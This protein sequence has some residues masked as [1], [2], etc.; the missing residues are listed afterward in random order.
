MKNSTPQTNPP[1]KSPEIIGPVTESDKEFPVLMVKDECQNPI[2]AILGFA[3][4]AECVSGEKMSGDYISVLSKEKKV[5]LNKH[6]FI[7]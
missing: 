4:H 1:R 7:I 6:R 2:G 5:S 3:C